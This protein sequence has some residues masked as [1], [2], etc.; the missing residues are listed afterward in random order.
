MSFPSPLTNIRLIPYSFAKSKG[1]VLK[2]L[3]ED[4]AEVWLREG[5]LAETLAEAKRV[6]GVKVR[7]SMVSPAEFD[8]LL[9]AA[10]SQDGVAALAG[11][12]ENDVD[13]SR[14]MQELPQ[15]EDLLESD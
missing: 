8:K 10:Y 6:L 11:N 14:L 3:T 2:S 7:A 5:A 12:L 1:V 9:T 15:I 13:L 4:V